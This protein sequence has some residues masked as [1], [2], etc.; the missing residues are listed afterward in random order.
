MTFRPEIYTRDNGLAY[1]AR[2]QTAGNDHLVL[3]EFGDFEIAHQSDARGGDWAYEA[4][5]VEIGGEECSFN[6][7]DEAMDWI[8]GEHLGGA[9]VDDNAEH[10]L[11]ARQLV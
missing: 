6:S 10:R 9:Y 5:T 1:A 2:V 11:T 8:E 7:I 4:V 3:V